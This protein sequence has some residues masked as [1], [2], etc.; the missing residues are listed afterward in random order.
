ADPF[1]QAPGNLQSYNRYSYVMNNPMSYTD[2]SGYIFKKINKAL[3]KFAP[4]FGIALMFVPGMQAWAAQSLLHAAA[5]GFLVGG[6]ST[7]SLRGAVIGAITGAAFHQVG[8][9]FGSKFGEFSEASLGQQAQ[10]AG[11]HAVVGGISSSLSGGKFGHGFFSAGFTKFSMGNAGFDYKN[12]SASAVA[13][14]V[15]IAAIIGGTA[16]VI[17]GGKFANGAQT[18]AMAQLLN[19]EA[20]TK[21]KLNNMMSRIG[22]GIDQLSKGNDIITIKSSVEDLNEVLG[23][24]KTRDELLDMIPLMDME[25]LVMINPDVKGMQISLARNYVAGSIQFYGPANNTRIQHMAGVSVM[26]LGTDAVVVIS[27]S[28][29]P[30]SAGRLLFALEMS[31][32]G[33]EFS[34]KN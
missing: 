6:V 9:H 13:G 15:S 23:F 22:K 20:S 11:G 12:T 26:A 31:E 1:V 33:Y 17:S 14:R 19:A 27:T 7:G 2:P 18:A 34:K 25:Q 16:S 5:T 29:L 24:S 3:G 30:V 4:V 32:V 8:S 21:N 28:L 10:W